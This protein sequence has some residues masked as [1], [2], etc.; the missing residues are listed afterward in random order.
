MGCNNSFIYLLMYVVCWEGKKVG[1]YIIIVVFFVLFGYNGFFFGFKVDNILES[2]VYE[3]YLI[4]IF[5]VIILRKLSRSK[6]RRKRIGVY[7]YM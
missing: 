2:Y 3:V 6:L 7:R 5:L 1:K 4:V